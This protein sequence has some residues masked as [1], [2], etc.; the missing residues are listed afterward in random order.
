MAMR[1]LIT[2]DKTDTFYPLRGLRQ[3][4]ILLFLC[5]VYGERG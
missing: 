4:H 3:G 5:L 2:G 1:V